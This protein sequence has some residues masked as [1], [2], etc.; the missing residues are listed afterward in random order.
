[1]APDAEGFRLPGGL[2][3]LPAGGHGWREAGKPWHPVEGGLKGLKTKTA[4]GRGVLAVA[5]LSL[6]NR[7]HLTIIPRVAWEEVSFQI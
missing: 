3:Y 6:I 4:T 2:A 7:D 5:E 1:M